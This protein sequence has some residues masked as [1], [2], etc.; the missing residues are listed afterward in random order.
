[1]LLAIDIGNT[2]ILLGGFQKKNLLFH[3]RL[4]TDPLRTSDEYGVSLLQ[5]LDTHKIKKG[6]I[7]SVIIA[8]VVPPLLHTITKTLKDYLGISPLLVGPDL[9]AGMKIRVGNPA[10]V[11]ADRIVN[12]VAARELYGTPAII[13]DF[14]TAITFDVIN[15]KGEYLGGAI[16]PGIGIS[17][18]ALV[19]RTSM[20]PK[21]EI[22]KPGKAIG[23]GTIPALQSGIFHGYIG[24]VE[25]LVRT[26]TAEMKEKPVVV[27]T[28]GMARLVAGECPA[29]DKIDPLLTLAGL[30]IIFE[31]NA[32]K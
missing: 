17:L 3:A 21:V 28:G 29:V 18:E 25:N 9:A 2:Q 15:H 13:V 7:K 10:E 16:A 4:Q 20:L 30:R 31:K 12:A 5:L 14:G 32:Q 27:A 19:E 11:G 26:I 6:R 8:C 22:K 23:D 1:M 24:L